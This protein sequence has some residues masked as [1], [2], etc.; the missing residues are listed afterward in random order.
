MSGRLDPPELSTLNGFIGEKLS[1]WQIMTGLVALVFAMERLAAS[2]FYA[3]FGVAPEEVGIGLTQSLVEGAALLIIIFAALSLISYFLL[4]PFFLLVIS[5][6]ERL[7]RPP[8]PGKEEPV[9]LRNA[10]RATPFLAI[11]LSAIVLIFTLAATILFA[12]QFS[13]R[14]QQ[15]FEVALFPLVPWRVQRVTVWWLETPPPPGA[16][17]QGNCVMFLGQAND[18]TV[19]FDAGAGRTLRLPTSSVLLSAMPADDHIVRACRT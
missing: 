19:L 9:T 7:T 2:L 15:G 3:Q 10:Q 16:G 4:I 17:I 18:V 8:V 6:V 12:I 1:L 13:Y 11:C 14:A 5:A